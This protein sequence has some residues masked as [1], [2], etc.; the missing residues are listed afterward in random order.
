MRLNLLTATFGLAGLSAAQ[1]ATF[2]PQ[3]DSE[4]CYSVNIPSTSASKGSGEIFFQI[5]GPASREWIGLGQGSQM[6]GANIFVIYADSDGKNITLSPRLGVGH[7]QPDY[8]SAA[9]VTLLEGSGI[10]NEVMTANIRCDNC[11][12]WSGG[13]MLF[14][15]S[16]SNWIYGIKAGAAVDSDSVSADI[17]QHDYNAP[18]NFDLTKAAGGSSANPF[19]QS[20]SSGSSSSSSGGGSSSPSSSGSA[21]SGSSSSDGSSSGAGDSMLSKNIHYAHGIIMSVAF[22]ILFPLGAI[23]IRTLHHPKT[24]WIHA[25]IQVFSWIAVLS[26]M[27]LGLWLALN[28]QELN[29]THAVIGLVVSTTLVIQPIG[30]LLHH[31]LYKRHQK[32]TAVSYGHIWLGRALITLGAINGGLGLQLAAN[33]SSSELVAYGVVAGLVYAL[34]ALVVAVTGVAK[35]KQRKD[36]DTKSSEM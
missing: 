21:S 5:K 31:S 25:A 2:C 14:T 34:Y 23:I 19:M 7:V 3:E 6:A 22:V 32:R 9:R 15:D 36:G 30:G 11:N 18:F 24:L 33:A 1:L 12:S 35:R 27:G 28:M 20:T 4:V 26:G 16:S 17:P 8:D 10:V 29:T 13:S